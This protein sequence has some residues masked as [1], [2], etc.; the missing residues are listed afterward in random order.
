M[1]P[2]FVVSVALV[3]LGLVA[4]RLIGLFPVL[5]A[6]RPI[7]RVD[8]LVAFIGALAL[9][10]HCLAMFF[11]DLGRA[12]PGGVAL[13]PVIGDAGVASGILYVLPAVVLLA[14]LRR[15]HPLAVA[16]NALGLLSVG[17]TMFDGGPAVVHLS[18]I[19]VEAVVL[20]VTVLAFVR[21]LVPR[22]PA[23]GAPVV[24]G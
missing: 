10:Y 19:A 11:P 7:G 22:A 12:V 1:P 4:L 17:V 3:V 13:V 24:G 5:A 8:A 15:L 18:A 9:G 23:Q 21:D 6:A 20:A 16:L 2:S 14:G